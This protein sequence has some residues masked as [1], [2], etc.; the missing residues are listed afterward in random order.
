M[1]IHVLKPDFPIAK[2]GQPQPEADEATRRLYE[3]ASSSIVKIETGDSRGSGFAAGAPGTIITDYH[4]VAGATE[5]KIRTPDGKFYR[6]RVTDI[7]DIND[8]AILKIE[9]TPPADLKPLKLAKTPLKADD[10]VFG[11]GHPN[12]LSP[13]YISPGSFVSNVRFGDK[14]FLTNVGR[15]LKDVLED[16]NIGPKDKL[17]WEAIGNRNTLYSRIHVR[18]GNSGGPLLNDKGEVVGIADLTADPEK[19]SH[20]I[21]TPAADLQKMMDRQ[22]PKF[23]FKY[24]H[25]GEHWTNEYRSLLREHTPE[26]LIGTGLGAGAGYYALTTSRRWVGRSAAFGLGLYGGASLMD[27]SREL[28]NSTN[29]MDRLKFGTASLADTTL[30]TGAAMRLL[31]R[32]VLTHSIEKTLLPVAEGLVLSSERSV[33]KHVLSKTGKV[34]MALLA[35]GVVTKIASDFIPNRLVQT[36]LSRTDGDLRPPHPLFSK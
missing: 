10:R 30:V 5:V 15:E 34:G 11:L 32:P 8:L 18:H 9:G 31:S 25:T 28:F 23:Q 2:P 13:I 4:C 21:F 6:A 27:D 35:A 7:D 1:D 36:D 19:Y 29:T 22:T 16:P 14:L 17:D 12:G 33:A 3:D 26:T 24:T 20:T